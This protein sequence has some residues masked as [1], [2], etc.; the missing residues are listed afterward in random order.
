MREERR[1]AQMDR[2]KLR[3][4]PTV[5]SGKTIITRPLQDNLVTSIIMA[6]S[7]VITTRP[8][9]DNIVTSITIAN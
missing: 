6:N 9:E 8:S 3:R 7:L 5:Q 4:G 2:T 1:G